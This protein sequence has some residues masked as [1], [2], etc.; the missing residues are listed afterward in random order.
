MR[1][2][3]IQ[4]GDG[5]NTGVFIPIEDWSLIKTNY[6]DVESLDKNLP[7]WQKELLDSRLQEIS[8]NPDRIKPID[9]LLKE[10]DSEV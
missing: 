7:A 2:Q 4:D 10:L 1:L 5:K 9:E 6:P 3:V 8:K